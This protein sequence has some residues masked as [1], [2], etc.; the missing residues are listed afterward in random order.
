M[1]VDRT[2][3]RTAYLD[4]QGEMQAAVRQRTDTGMWV[5]SDWTQPV[6]TTRFSEFDTREAA[7]ASA[8]KLA[9]GIR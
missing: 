7:E 2:D 3:T 4:S 6:P 5:L 1:K 8:K 9:K